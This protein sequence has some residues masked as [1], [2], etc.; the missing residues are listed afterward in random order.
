MACWAACCGFP[1][2]RAGAFFSLND[3]SATEGWVSSPG[4]AKRGAGI[5]RLRAECSAGF[6]GA[7]TPYSNRG[8][9]L[10]LSKEV[11]S[12]ELCDRLTGVAAG[13]LN[14]I[15]TAWPSRETL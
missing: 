2:G 11:V 6:R 4:K 3:A 13:A 10:S 8:R 12:V 1:S 14:E 15:T 5:C 7:G 9:D